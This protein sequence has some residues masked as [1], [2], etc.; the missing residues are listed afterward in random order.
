M[1]CRSFTTAE[2]IPISEVQFW[3]NYTTCNND[4]SLRERED[5]NVLDVDSYSIR[6]NLT[7]SLEGYYTCGKQVDENCIKSTKRELICKYNTLYVYIRISSIS[8]TMHNFLVYCVSTE[9]EHKYFEYQNFS[10]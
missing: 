5:V 10:A 7:R 2:N 1:L 8:C 3:L 9:N 6:F 4:T